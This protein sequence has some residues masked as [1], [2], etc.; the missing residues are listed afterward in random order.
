LIID[1]GEAVSD[2][3]STVLDVSGEKP[4]L[5]REGVVTREQLK[6]TYRLVEINPENS[7]ET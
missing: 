2:K 3:P 5:I 4:R 6:R 1:G 7:S